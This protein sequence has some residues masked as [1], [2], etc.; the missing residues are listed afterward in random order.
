MSELR[1]LTLL[2]EL[3][4]VEIA[5][6]PEND[7][8]MREIIAKKMAEGVKFFIVKPFLGNMLQR[9]ARLRTVAD[10][11]KHRVSIKDEDIENLFV[12]EKIAMYRRDSGERI[13]TTGIAKTPEQAA[14]TST[15]GVRQFQGG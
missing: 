12:A 6:E 9:K 15:V 10:L 13:Q 7:A 3:G 4:D 8:A 1:T 5:W 14:S 2:N 11:D